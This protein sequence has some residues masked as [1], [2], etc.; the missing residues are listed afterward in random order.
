MVAELLGTV[1]ADGSLELAGKVALPAGPVRVR[2]EPVSAPAPPAESLLDFVDRTRRELEAAG[3][4]FMDDED[5]A[6]WIE[7]QRDGG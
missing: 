4:R 2:V 3:H 5:V 6:A 1:T 7:E